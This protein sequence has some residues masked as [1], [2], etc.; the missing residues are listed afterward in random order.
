MKV[1][2]LKSTTAD[3]P[4]PD[5]PEV[6]FV[7]RSNVG[8]SSL[9]NMVTGRNIARVSKEPGR[10]RTI[11]YFL[12]NDS[13]YLVDVPGYGFARVPKEEQDKWKRMM[14]N[15][16]KGRKEN[17]RVVFLLIDAVAGVQKLDRQMIEWLQ[18]VGLPFVVVLTKT[19]KAKQKELSRTLK[20]VKELVGSSAIVMSSARE[21]R[22][23]KEILSRIF[24]P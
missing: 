6:V 14:E 12:L 23:K 9:I 10:T 16:F 24:A 15:Y 13:V 5:K 22:G 11:N 1:E 3:F 19:D 4:P 8:K 2:F 17:I 18:F 21:G 20:Q 7:G